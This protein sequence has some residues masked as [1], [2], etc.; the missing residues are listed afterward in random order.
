MLILHAY[1]LSFTYTYFHLRAMQDNHS[2]NFFKFSLSSYARTRTGYKL[3]RKHEQNLTS[4]LY[5]NTLC[6]YYFFPVT[7]IQRI[8]NDSGGTDILGDRLAALIR[9][10]PRPTNGNLTLSTVSVDIRATLWPSTLMHGRPF[11]SGCHPDSTIRSTSFVRVRSG[12][13]WV[14][15]ALYTSVKRTTPPSQRI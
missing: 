13:T 5:G 8:F 6:Y 10:I 14:P 2:F 7:K 4:S 12:R 15:T 1:I 3:G 9:S 11:I